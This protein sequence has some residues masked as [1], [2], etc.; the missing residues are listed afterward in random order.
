[1]I[2]Y[3]KRFGNAA[4]M[5]RHTVKMNMRRISIIT[6]E[7]V[8]LTMM[9]G[10]VMHPRLDPSPVDAG[11]FRSTRGYA[12]GTDKLSDMNIPDNDIGKFI[13]YGVFTG[14]LVAVPLAIATDVALSPLDAYGVWQGHQ[15]KEEFLK[16]DEEKTIRPESEEE[17]RRGYPI[18]TEAAGWHFNIQEISSGWNIVKGSDLYGRTVQ[19]E[20]ENSDDLLKQCTAD[21]ID[22]NKQSLA[23]QSIEPIVTTPVESGKG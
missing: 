10:C 9:T 2:T 8:L 6:A 22:I 20:G 18:T 23:N 21:A 7:I 17:I 12:P 15:A 4:D 1:M 13:N 3:E 11:F 16:Q 19:R 5:N 14:L